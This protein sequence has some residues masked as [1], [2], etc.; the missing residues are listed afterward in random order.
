[1]DECIRTHPPNYIHIR[2]NIKIHLHIYTQS[3]TLVHCLTV[4]GIQ[5][6]SVEGDVGAM[7]ALWR[8]RGLAHVHVSC[9]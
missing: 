7:Q 4:W 8:G 9:V 5:G 2:I 3:R 6:E 1:M